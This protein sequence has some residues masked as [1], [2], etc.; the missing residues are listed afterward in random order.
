MRK[1]KKDNLF[2]ILAIMV[3]ASLFRNSLEIIGLSTSSLDSV[4]DAVNNYAG[5]LNTFT[6]LLLIIFGGVFG[7]HLFLRGKREEL[8]Q[9]IYSSSLFMI[10]LFILVPILNS[11]FNYHGPQLPMWYEYN[12]PFFIYPMYLP[13]GPA[14]GFAVILLVGPWIVKKIYQRPLKETFIKV[15]GF[16]FLIFY[17]TYQ[18]GLWFVNFLRPRSWSINFYNAY[19]WTFLVPVM[20]IFPFFI[21]A[22]FGKRN[23]L[24]GWLV[25][26]F[27]WLIFIFTGRFLFRR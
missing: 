16:F 13:I 24:Q 6:Y 3:V 25:Y 10:P 18:I 15:F 22:Y 1:L 23:K 27:I 21:R 4:Y 5:Y 20:I 8:V 2:L 19:S 12:N 9:L 11:A 14:V 17:Y 26:G 7:I